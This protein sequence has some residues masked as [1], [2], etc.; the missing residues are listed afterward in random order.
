ME[1]GRETFFSSR[2]N[3]LVLDF[4]YKLSVLARAK[5]ELC[6]SEGVVGECLLFIGLKTG[7]KVAGEIGL[8]VPSPESTRTDEWLVE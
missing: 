4:S 7:L 8:H 2:G 3:D 5:N 6:G 1:K